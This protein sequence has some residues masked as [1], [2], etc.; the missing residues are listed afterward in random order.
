MVAE[1]IVLIAIKLIS[2][3]VE[4]GPLMTR[5]FLFLSKEAKKQ[6]SKDVEIKIQIR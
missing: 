1:S 6:R 2:G 5:S 4:G 3:E